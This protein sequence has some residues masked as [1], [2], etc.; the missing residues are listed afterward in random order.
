MHELTTPSSVVRHKRRASLKMPH[1]VINLQKLGPKLGEYEYL[2][3]CLKLGSPRFG[4]R[5]NRRHVEGTSRPIGRHKA[6]IIDE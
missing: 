1:D 5:Y 6:A 4:R 2:G 3:M